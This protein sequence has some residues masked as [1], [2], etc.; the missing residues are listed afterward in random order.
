MVRCMCRNLAYSPDL[1][2]LRMPVSSCQ[3]DLIFLCCLTPCERCELP[4]KQQEMTVQLCSM[5]TEI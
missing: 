4:W 5:L 3:Q 1:C 2:C